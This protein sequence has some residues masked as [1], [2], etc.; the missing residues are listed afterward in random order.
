VLLEAGW[1]AP[2]IEAL[3]AIGAVEQA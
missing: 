3:I 1:S 2:D